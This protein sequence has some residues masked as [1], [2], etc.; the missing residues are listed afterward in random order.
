MNVSCTKGC[1][2][3][4]PGGLADPTEGVSYLC[5]GVLHTV[6]FLR[7]LK[8]NALMTALCTE[9]FAMLP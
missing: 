8:V 1:T 3:L 4:G 5:G 6:P 9:E 7:Y 2:H